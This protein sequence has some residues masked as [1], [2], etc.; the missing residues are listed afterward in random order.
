MAVMSSWVH[1]TVFSF[2]IADTHNFQAIFQICA[3]FQIIFKNQIKPNLIWHLNLIFSLQERGS[4]Q[5][6]TREAAPKVLNF[7]GK[8]V[9]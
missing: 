9:S 3:N 1:S 2:A 5:S 4:C 6:K 8:K 7:K